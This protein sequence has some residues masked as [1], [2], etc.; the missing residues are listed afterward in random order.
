MT[1]QGWS[2][3]SWSS[4][5]VMIY[6]DNWPTLKNLSPNLEAKIYIQHNLMPRNTKIIFIFKNN[7]YI[8]HFSRLF[9]L[10]TRLPLLW[11]K[12]LSKGCQL[13]NFLLWHW[14]SAWHWVIVRPAFSGGLTFDSWLDFGQSQSCW[15]KILTSPW[16]EYK[17]PIKNNLI[18]VIFGQK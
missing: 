17:T 15:A 3:Q 6:L 18:F 9:C 12:P 11:L 16:L 1:C 2:L 8:Y 4:L 14:Q 13:S 7:C 5:T 10:L